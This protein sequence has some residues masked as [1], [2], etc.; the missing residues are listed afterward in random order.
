VHHAAQSWKG[1]DSYRS[2]L[3]VAER[4]NYELRGRIEELERE[5]KSLR[6]ELAHAEPRA[7]S[8]RWFRQRSS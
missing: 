4:R 8:R 5:L 7:D 3:K 2:A 1:I 6:S